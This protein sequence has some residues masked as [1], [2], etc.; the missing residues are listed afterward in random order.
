MILKVTSN[1]FVTMCKFEENVQKMTFENCNLFKR[2]FTT[3]GMGYTFNN[4]REEN[5]IKN[6]YRNKEF[7]HNTKRNPSLM[8]YTSTDHSLI[9]IINSNFEEVQIHEN[10]A[11]D[12]KKDD[13]GPKPKEIYVS[14]HNPKEPADINFIPVTSIDS[15]WLHHNISYHST[16]KRNRRQW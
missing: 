2:S 12:T 9:A 4:E 5:L 1:P 13:I 7:L 14:V 10:L 8:K 3:Q 11:G 15:T 6:V 16:S